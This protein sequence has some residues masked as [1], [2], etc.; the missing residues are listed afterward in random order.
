[1]PFQKRS[2]IS[3]PVQNTKEISYR[4]H[5]VNYPPEHE[6]KDDVSRAM[7]Y[8]LSAAPV[9]KVAGVG[10]YMLHWTPDDGVFLTI[11]VFVR[12][13]TCHTFMAIC[14]RGGKKFVLLPGCDICVWDRRIQAWENESYINN[15]LMN[16]PPN[17]DA[18][19]MASMPGNVV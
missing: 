5:A 3:L 7:E 10:Y 2:R 12:E 13:N 4:G 8:I 6:L 18:Y 15:C 17:F 1:M 11:N 14:P 16:D 9:R 19:L